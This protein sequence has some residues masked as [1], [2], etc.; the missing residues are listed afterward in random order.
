MANGQVS[1]ALKTGAANNCFAEPVVVVWGL[2]SGW[3]NQSLERSIEI[4]S[5]FFI[6][7]HFPLFFVN[8]A[9]VLDGDEL[10]AAWINKV[11]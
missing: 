3:K 10:D 7:S 6:N 11:G 9:W 8:G 2:C 4:K 5:A 1:V